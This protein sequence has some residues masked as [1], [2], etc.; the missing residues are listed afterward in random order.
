M[1]NRRMQDW[2]TGSRLGGITLLPVFTWYVLSIEQIQVPVEQQHLFNAT[3][4]PAFIGI[5]GLAVCLWLVLAPGDRNTLKLADFASLQ[6]SRLGIFACLMLGFAIS[7]ERL[8]F[9]LPGIGFL[10]LGALVLKAPSKLHALII[11]TSVT[12]TLWVGLRFVVGLY[13]PALGSG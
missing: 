8:G 11:A 9:L 5:G 3:S 12:L 2:L 1:T 4:L 6:W 13:L 7:I 10:F